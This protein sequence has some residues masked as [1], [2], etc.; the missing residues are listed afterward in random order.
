M[1]SPLKAVVDHHVDRPG[2]EA[3]RSVQLT[4]TN[5]LIGLIAL[6]ANALPGERTLRSSLRPERRPGTTTDPTNPR[7]AL[8]I[9]Q[10]SCRG[11]RVAR[12]VLRRPGGCSE[13]PE[14]DPIPN[15]AVKLLS[16]DGTM[17]QDLGE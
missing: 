5:R 15:S 8:A 10:R 2:V 16:A 14:P 6:I 17:S 12:P 13:E 4:G 3:E 9:L 1:S 11:S 7:F